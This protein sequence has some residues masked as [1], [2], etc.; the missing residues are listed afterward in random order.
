MNNPI[1]ATFYR[2]RPEDLE[3]KNAPCRF[4]SFDFF[5]KKIGAQKLKFLP[6]I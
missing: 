4:S 1:D 3:L 6:K 2:D 5:K